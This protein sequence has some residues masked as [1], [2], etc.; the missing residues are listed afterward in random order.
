MSQ[1]YGHV[2]QM[3]I[4]FGEEIEVSVEAGVWICRSVPSNGQNHILCLRGPSFVV[5]NCAKK[6]RD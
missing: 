4:E 2:T 5:M 1:E 3:N 6:N